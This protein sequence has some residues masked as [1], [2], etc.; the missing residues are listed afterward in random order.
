MGL[1][2]IEWNFKKVLI[3]KK[4]FYFIKWY[5]DDVKVDDF[6]FGID[7]NV[8]VVL[9]YEVNMVSYICF[10]WFICESI[11]G[12]FGCCVFWFGILVKSFFK[13]SRSVIVE[14]VFQFVGVC[15]VG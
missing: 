14:E 3:G 4:M 10:K 8:I 5:L 15:S 11:V 12:D 2:I 9:F 7:K 1:Y 6:K 13:L